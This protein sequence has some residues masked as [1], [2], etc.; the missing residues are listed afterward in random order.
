MD[1]FVAVSH[2]FTR[3]R[4]TSIVSLAAYR[5][6]ES[7]RDDS[8]GRRH[9]F[10]HE[11]A[12]V[13]HA[14]IVR[15][16]NIDSIP[17]ASDRQTLWNHV[18]LAT[19]G[20]RAGLAREIQ[21][22][23]PAELSHGAKVEISR[24]YAQEIADRYQT[25]VDLAVHRPR[26][27]ADPR[28][29][30]VH[31][32]M[33]MRSVHPDGL[34]DLTDLATGPAALNKRGQPSREAQMHAWSERWVSL[35]NEALVREGHP[36]RMT[37]SQLDELGLVRPS[38]LHVSRAAYALVLEG[39]PCDAMDR[40]QT[41]RDFE[42]RRYEADLRQAELELR[43]TALLKSKL[44]LDAGL[45]A[46][47]SLPLDPDYPTDHASWLRWRSQQ[48]FDLNPNSDA[49]ISGWREVRGQKSA[50]TDPTRRH[51]LRGA[52]SGPPERVSDTDTR[53]REMD[54]PDAGY[55]LEP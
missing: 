30:H 12:R 43:K 42:L 11:A 9:N 39:K 34:G 45:D 15:P 14:G 32:L 55:A 53:S 8:T 6:G 41:R 1:R 49:W 18:Q 23:L 2:A 7:L 24:M 4:H 19:R 36:A 51:E 40:E 48:T 47:T 17:F 20:T 54:T 5:A 52:T 28:S 25:L 26:P 38:P 16:E 29:F 3:A 31:L 21:V 50:P 37:T 44:D 10:E 13:M 22:N 33:P 27:S 46:M 35:G